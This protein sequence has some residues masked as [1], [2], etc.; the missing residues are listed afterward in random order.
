[1]K[2]VMKI[3]LIILISLSFVAFFANNSLAADDDYIDLS[4][5]LNNTSNTSNTNN[6]TNTNNLNNIS[7]ALNNTNTNNTNNSSSYNSTS[8]PKTGIADSIPTALLVVLFGISAIYAY[9][10]I[11]DYKNL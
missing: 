1:M 7:N 6:T 5:T 11:S 10:K 9:K 4:N 8:L 3:C 2:K